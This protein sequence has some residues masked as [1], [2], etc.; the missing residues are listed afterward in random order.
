MDKD[1]I[2]QL[3]EAHKKSYEFAT[4]D[5]W[6]YIREKYL[7][8][9]LYRERKFDD[10]I[11]CVADDFGV[12]PKYV[13]ERIADTKELRKNLANLERAHN[14]MRKASLAVKELIKTG[15]YPK[16]IRFLKLTSLWTWIKERDKK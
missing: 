15:H 3:D 4:T 11:N 10:I 8:N 12:Y 14:E 2:K 5:I 16:I 7:H 13:R 6:K 1:L 9:P